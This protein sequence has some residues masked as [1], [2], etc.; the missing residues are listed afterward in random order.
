MPEILTADRKIR[1]IAVY[2]KVQVNF[3]IH[4][5]HTHTVT[6]HRENTNA[7]KL[8]SVSMEYLKNDEKFSMF[9]SCYMCD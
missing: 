1:F 6:N 7:M 3:D 4:S 9:E 8:F 2:T 5:T